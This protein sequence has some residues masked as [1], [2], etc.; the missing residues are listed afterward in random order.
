MERLLRSQA[1]YRQTLLR[2][3]LTSLVLFE[4][5][6][7]TTAKAR[8]LLPFVNRMINRM[9][10]GD[11][12]AVRL[13]NQTFL[14]AN[15]AKKL[16]EEILPRYSKDETNYVRTYRLM[17]RRGDSAPQMMVAFT[18]TLIAKPEK[19]VE[20]TPTAEKPATTKTKKAK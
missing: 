14:D 2:N 10:T 5:L 17:P 9:K 1:D 6:T 13:A 15:A 19:A 20:E 16:F 11:M 12:N 3:Q 18:K 8:Q 7:T 4:T